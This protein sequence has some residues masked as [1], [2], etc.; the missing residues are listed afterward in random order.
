[1]NQPYFFHLKNQHQPSA[2]LSLFFFFYEKKKISLQ[3][4]IQL[5]SA[6]FKVA[7]PQASAPVSCGG[8]AASFSPG[9]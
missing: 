5:L 8:H 3:R 1:M 6:E 2:E 4:K 9:R 7:E